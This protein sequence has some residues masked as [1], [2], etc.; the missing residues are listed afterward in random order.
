M[1]LP[2]P[3]R[4]GVFNFPSGTLPLPFRTVLPKLHGFSDYVD[5]LGDLAISVDVKI[6][7]PITEAA[8]ILPSIA[9]QFP[10][11][12]K[13]LEKQAAA[14]TGTVDAVNI[15]LQSLGVA[16]IFGGIIFI[17]LSREKGK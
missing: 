2:L 14:V 15:G 16:V 7:K 5:G 1:D 9:H 10:Q 6:P 8:K 3:D 12:A 4:T 11:Y 17:L 13:E